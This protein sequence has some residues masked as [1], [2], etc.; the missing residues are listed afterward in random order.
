V[1]HFCWPPVLGGRSLLLASILLVACDDPVGTGRP[2]PDWPFDPSGLWEGDAQGNLRG[3][4]LTSPLSVSLL[5]DRDWCPSCLQGTWQWGGL[6]GV[7]SAYW[8][9]YGPSECYPDPGVYCPFG[10]TLQAPGGEACSKPPGI[11]GDTYAVIHLRAEF[12]GQDTLVVRELRGT[13][14][15]GA[16]AGGWPCPGPE[17]V[18]FNTALVLL[19]VP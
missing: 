15:Q 16:V 5:D 4:E 12:H 3:V 9:F 6:S 14:W 10:V 1:T 13:Y 19:R 2:D 17:L 7:A 18:S 11:P 8:D